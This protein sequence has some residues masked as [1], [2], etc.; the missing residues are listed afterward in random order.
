MRTPSPVLVIDAAV[1][2]AAARGRS[3]GA[4]LEAARAAALVTDRVVQEAR[5]RVELGL[6]RPDLLAVIDALAAGLTIVRVAA[7]MPILAG[8]EVALRDAVPSRNGSTRDAPKD[9]NVLALAWSVEADVWTT[10]HDFAGTGIAS[11]ST[12]NLTPASAACRV[13]R[14]ADLVADHRHQAMARRGNA[15]RLPRS[16][17]ASPSNDPGVCATANRSHVAG[18]WPIYH[19]GD[20]QPDRQNK[21]CPIGPSIT[22]AWARCNRQIE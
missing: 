14:Q 10:D 2:V 11:G 1:L 15:A 20:E 13:S 21:I 18:L 7:L 19:R 6:K 9:A 17:F 3:S 5:R 12:P 4:M 16:P 22:T 8:S